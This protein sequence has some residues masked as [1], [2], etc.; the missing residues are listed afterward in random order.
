VNKPVGV[1]LTIDIQW[2]NYLGGVIPNCRQ[3]IQGGHCVLL[4][5]G[6]ADGTT[7]INT[8]FWKIKNSWG[9]GYG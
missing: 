4:V 6:M 5:G 1:C 3:A 8:N 2:K 7:N 9:T